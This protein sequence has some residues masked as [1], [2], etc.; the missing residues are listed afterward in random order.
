MLHTKNTIEH[1]LDYEENI[2]YIYHTLLDSQELYKKY[3]DSG[4]R[5]AIRY[6][7]GDLGLYL[8]IG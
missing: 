8:Y 3:Y 4:R 7:P 5:Q 2:D 6:K 1:L